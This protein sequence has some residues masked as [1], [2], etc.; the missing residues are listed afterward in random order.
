MLGFYPG[1]AGVERRDQGL[2][3]RSCMDDSTDGD[4]AAG[5]DEWVATMALLAKVDR[6]A[7]RALRALAW[8]HAKPLADS[9]RAN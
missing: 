5:R 9:E 7:Y 8:K 3:L 1:V 4:E 6:E 2:A